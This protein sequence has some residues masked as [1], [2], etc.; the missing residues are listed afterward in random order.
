MKDALGA[1]QSI[2]ALGGGSDIAQAT[3]DELAK[4]RLRRAV[5]A[6]RS[7]GSL[8]QAVERAHAAGVTD[9]TTIAFDALD[10][11]SHER[12]IAEAFAGGDID[13]VLVAFGLLGN[14]ADLDDDPAAAAELVAVNMGGAVSAVSAAAKAMKAQGHGTIVVLS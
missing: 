3:V 5:L 10:P 11:Q 2:L 6:A 13:V 14:Q 8:G 4:G 12:V 1:V 7:P 9:V